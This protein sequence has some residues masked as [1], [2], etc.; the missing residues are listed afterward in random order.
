[1]GATQI[2]LWQAV[3]DGDA[4]ATLSACRALEHGPA[5][6]DRSAV[7]AI[8]AQILRGDIWSG[9][10][11]SPGHGAAAAIAA[12]SVATPAELRGL[13]RLPVPEEAVAVELLTKRDLAF[14]R[15]WCARA[16]DDILLPA[17]RIA[18][19]LI[20]A[21]LVERPDTE[22]YTLA[23]VSAPAAFDLQHGAGVPWGGRHRAPLEVLRDQPELLAD[24]WRIFEVEGGGEH[25]LAA[26]DK[27]SSADSTWSR[28]LLTLSA[29]GTLDR[30]RLLDASLATLQRGFAQFRAQWF[31]AFHEALQPTLQER[32]SRAEH[33]LALAS[34]PIGPTVTLALNAL[35]ILQRAQ[36]LDGTRAVDGLGLALLTPAKGSALKAL[37]LVTT[38]VRQDEGLVPLATDRVIA[39]L[40]HDA[41]DVQHAA[42]AR[43]RDWHPQPSAALATE[44]LPL[45]AGCHAAV[46][47]ELAE[48]LGAD[49]Q[50]ATHAHDRYAAAT[51]SQISAVD[52]LAA[53]RAVAP[54]TDTDE[55]FEQASSV[56][57]HPSSPEDIERIITYLSEHGPDLSAA[58]Q[59]TTLARR[60]GAL[61]R[62]SAHSS[63]VLIGEMFCT[64][65]GTMSSE[66]W[67]GPHQ[68][69][70]S[71]PAPLVCIDRLLVQRVRSLAP[72]LRAHLPFTPLA[73][74]THRGGVIDPVVFAERLQRSEQ[75]PPRPELLC[76]LLRL[77]PVPERLAAARGMLNDRRHRDI[78]QHLGL[79]AAH[80]D[81]DAAAGA[82]RTS[83]ITRSGAS[84]LC[85]FDLQGDTVVS[86]PA[87]PEAISWYGDRWGAF[88]GV[89][90]QD[91]A[92][93]RWLSS[94]MPGHP[95]AWA[96][97][98]VTAIGPTYQ[99]KDVAHGDVA[100][101]DRCFDPATPMGESA[102]FLLA[103][104]LNDPR[105]A[106][107]S[108]AVDLAIATI[109]DRR[110]DP[111]QLGNHV[112]ALTGTGCVTPPRWAR[113]LRDVAGH[114][115]L[116]ADAV[117]QVLEHA[118][119]RAVPRSAS[120]M[121]KLL[122]LT[123]A[124]VRE[125]GFAIRNTDALDA[126]RQLT[127]AG[128][129][130][131]AA[132]RVLALCDD[133]PGGLR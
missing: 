82:Q 14:R 15:G 79:W 4:E 88:H 101:L 107:A 90:T 2:D 133:G 117:A 42:V 31:C 65:F 104:A 66:G 108:A 128:K 27:Y 38:A 72:Q 78:R 21:G 52:W 29:D 46:R 70:A 1:M 103:F 115:V 63:Q 123:E 105:G 24:V 61:V 51:R 69:I 48:W 68:R 43:L 110:F 25:S 76:A 100:F 3:F 23:L 49:D 67:L 109:D 132:A 111:A 118:F 94:L 62:R 57:E 37:R 131:Q 93:I 80:C 96:R 73:A 130:A 85:E 102:H 116:H 55:F 33:Y 92:G 120:D 45:H 26:H 60:A 75:E 22:G 6:R 40:G 106:V 81:A 98:G 47:D 74:P 41:L 11:Y 84:S 32:A 58:G 97:A 119:A 9:D 16:F 35:T 114:S 125:H 127:G 91:P 126:L 87:M 8:C 7:V 56:L 36:L 54:L 39:A 113:T 124:L 10:E 86:T 5:P 19:R 44:L 20:M 64:A 112:A 121:L 12:V 17:I 28:A 53:E 30:D 77:A 34:S 18:R 129:T 71:I 89:F 99:T 50:V 13:R 122:E 59:A 95:D 83:T